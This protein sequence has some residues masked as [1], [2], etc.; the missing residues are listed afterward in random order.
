[1]NV[2]KL[3]HLICRQPAFA[4]ISLAG[5][6]PSK[7]RGGAD[8]DTDLPQGRDKGSTKRRKAQKKAEKFRSELEQLTSE[9]RAGLARTA[10]ITGVSAREVEVAGRKVWFLLLSSY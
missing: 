10:A 7:G 5:E 4:S 8:I 6:L 1:M 9:E 2:V 3:R